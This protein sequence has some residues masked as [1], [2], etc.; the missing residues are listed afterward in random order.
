[1]RLRFAILALVFFAIPALLGR[2]T[3]AEMLHG[4]NTTSH[5]NVRQRA[6]KKLGEL[7]VAKE[8]RRP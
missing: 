3:L 1:M 6:G 8:F 5:L 4:T 7:V 2:K